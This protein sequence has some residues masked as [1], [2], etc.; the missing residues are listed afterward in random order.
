MWT[1]PCLFMKSFG[2]GVT[3]NPADKHA[4][5]AL[6][7]GNLTM[8]PAASLGGS[9]RATIS[10]NTGM[11]YMEIVSGSTTSNATFSIGVCDST[12]NLASG[13]GITVGNNAAISIASTGNVLR[14]GSS[15]GSAMSSWINGDVIQIAVNIGAGKFY[16]RKNNGSWGNSGN[17]VAGTGGYSFTPGAATFP[18]GS[19]VN[20]TSQT[21][22]FS[23]SSWTGVAPAGYGE[24]M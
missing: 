1:M 12:Q 8:Q 4:N 17:P 18:A 19:V 15:Q 16:V 11:F 5:V 7:N 3:W 14:G 2:S 9:A 6:I 21:A 13:I 22:R 23:S 24:W 20:L 10:K